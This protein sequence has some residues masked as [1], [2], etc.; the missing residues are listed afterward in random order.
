MP[1]RQRARGLLGTALVRQ[2]L[3]FLKLVPLAPEHREL[4]DE[5]AH[6]GMGVFVDFSKAGQLGFSFE[7]CTVQLSEPLIFRDRSMTLEDAHRC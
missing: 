5:I 3:L 4:C 2:L 6:V 1:R 7:N